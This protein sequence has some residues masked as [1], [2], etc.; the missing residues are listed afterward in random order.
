MLSERIERALEEG[1][2][3]REALR[4]QT[5]DIERMA[6]ACATSLSSGGKLMFAGNG[7]SAADAQHLATELVVRLSPDRE[8]AA[9]AGLALTTDSSLLTACAND[10][11]FDHIFAR[12]VEALG[13]PGDILFAISTSG[14]SRNIIAAAHGARR[15]D[16][17]VLGL[18]GGT[19]GDLLAECDQSIV[20]A[21]GNPGRVQELH[22]TIG[23]I[24]IEL[25][26]E[27]LSA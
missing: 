7:G 27:L 4:G 6:R 22:I 5:G 1:L 10:F 11:S 15:R 20:V 3:L 9:L 16:I 19:G 14:R 8:R 18:L 13:Q 26:E 25:V 21:S 12:Q 17:R 23:H 24:L 2:K